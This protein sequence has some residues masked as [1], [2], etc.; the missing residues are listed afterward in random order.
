MAAPI[1]VWPGVT[2]PQAAPI[3]IEC[4]LPP[5]PRVPDARVR[6]ASFGVKPPMTLF[7]MQH[8]Y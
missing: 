8:S 1:A 2:V 5:H 6:P 3:H 4:D 7:H